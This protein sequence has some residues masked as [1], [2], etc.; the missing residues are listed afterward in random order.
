MSGDEYFMRL[1]LLEAEKAFRLGEVPIGSIL[2][3]NGEVVASGYNQVEAL[4]DASAHAEMICLRLA[5]K[6]LGNWRLVGSTL[7][8]TLEPCSM[9]AG[10]LI[11][12]RV[13]NVVWG[14]PDLRHGACGSWINLFEKKHP[15]HSVAIRSG[16][17]ESECSEI[18][19]KFFRQ[20]REGK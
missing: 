13:E 17:L 8:S 15:I 4:C 1:A 18:V 14:A 19:R 16:V 20:V 3:V 7:Y 12:S 6:T 10:A 11:L 9:C 5:S 2:V